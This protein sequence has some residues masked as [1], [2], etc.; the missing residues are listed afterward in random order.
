MSSRGTL[1][2]H[3]PK[4]AKEREELAA[5]VLMEEIAAIVRIQQHTRRKVQPS[6]ECS[7]TPASEYS[8][9]RAAHETD[10]HFGS[11]AMNSGVHLRSR[12]R[13]LQ[14]RRARNSVPCFRSARGVPRRC[15]PTLRRSLLQAGSSQDVLGTVMRGAVCR[16]LVGDP[17]RCFGYKS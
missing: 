8:R 4:I 10:L 6:S 7:R 3:D 17:E 14:R 9:Q 13:S 12:R 11:T 5:I 15:V 16:C 1:T 2:S